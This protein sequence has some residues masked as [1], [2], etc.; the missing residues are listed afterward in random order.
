MLMIGVLVAL[1]AL[2]LAA[3]V[4]SRPPSPIKAARKRIDA[5]LADVRS[6]L[7]ALQMYDGGAVSHLEELTRQQ[8]LADQLSRP[9]ESLTVPG[10]GEAMFETLREHAVIKVKDVELLRARKVP[11]VGEKRAAQL[12]ST[13]QEERARLQAEAR[14]L[15]RSAL[16][17][18]AGGKL[19]ALVEQEAADELQRQRELECAQIR[20][21]ELERRRAQLGQ[22][23]SG[24][25]H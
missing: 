3:I 1:L 9:L 4:L 10:F 23:Q 25:T 2:V 16:D 19:S 17:Q 12:W 5:Q 15:D 6:Q 13:Y 11:G 20:L 7:V 18:I 8:W 22:K 14:A 24:V 21:A